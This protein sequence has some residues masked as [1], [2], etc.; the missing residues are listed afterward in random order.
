MS[1]LHAKNAA[2]FNKNPEKVTR[3]D[4]T[5]WKVRMDHD[6]AAAQLP[7]WEALRD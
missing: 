2:A 3:H 5:F 6:A 7:E 4:K 1:T